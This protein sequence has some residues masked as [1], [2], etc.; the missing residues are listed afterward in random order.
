M[1]AEESKAS[2]ARKFTRQCAVI[3][4]KDGRYSPDAYLFVFEG[5]EFTIRRLGRQGHVTGREL[6]E[7]IRDHAI[8]QFGGLARMVLDRWGVRKTEDF[9]EIVFRL[10]VEGMMGK[11]DT[12]SIDDFR[13]VYDF[14]AAFPLT[15]TPDEA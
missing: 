10:V 2:L 6:S 4:R 8:E 15:A 3:A 13:D 14:A 11:T 5:L 9:G 7:G 1:G 12:D